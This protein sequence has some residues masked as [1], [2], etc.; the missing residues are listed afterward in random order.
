MTLPSGLTAGF[1]L[2]IG[3]WR[4]ERIANIA[5]ISR[6]E[7]LSL[8]RQGIGGSDAAAICGQN[9][10]RSPLAV[11]ADKKAL[12]PDEADND[13]FLFGRRMER[14]LRQWF[15]EDFA[16]QEDKAIVVEEHPFM[17]RSKQWPWMIGNIDGLVQPKDEIEGGLELKARDR[18]MAKH[19]ADDS[20]MDS[21]Y[22]QVQHYMAL[23]GLTYFYVVILL[24][25]KLIWRRVIRNEKYIE[26]LVEAEQRFWTDYVLTGQAPA[27][28]GLDSDDDVLKALYGIEE[29]REVMLDE[30][31]TQVESYVAANEQEKVLA[32]EKQRLRQLVESRMGTAKYAIAGD[33]KITWSRFEMRRM[34]I[35]RL[36]KD[37]PEL[38]ARY[39]KAIPSSRF[40]V[41]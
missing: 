31:R 30:L 32:K 18:F 22:A 23:T 16:A 12:I 10:W 4:C 14:P 3:R 11:Y 39:T 40:S 2:D 19:Y 9:P 7:W 26:W 13:S 35:D 25:K 27:P 5:E 1:D 38:A 37:D 20:V 24:G 34:D 17:Y 28:I 21:D 36:R 15:A 6:E 29:E 41:R 8:R 33:H